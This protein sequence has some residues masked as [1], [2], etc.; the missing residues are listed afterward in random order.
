MYQSSLIINVTKRVEEVHLNI[1]RIQF[2]V[3]PSILDTLFYL[4]LWH[5][6]KYDF[7]KDGQLHVRAGRGL[8]RRPGQQSV[9][10]GVHS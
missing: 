2:S 7:V 4:R 8:R 10:P 9:L 1:L 3:I 5:N 6:S